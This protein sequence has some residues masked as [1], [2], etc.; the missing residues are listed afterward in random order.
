MK[1]E[2]VTGVNSFARE[3]GQRGLSTPKKK[4]EAPKQENPFMYVPVGQK[5]PKERMGL[6][7]DKK[8]VHVMKVSTRGEY[9]NNWLKTGSWRE[10][11]GGTCY[12]AIIY[13]WVFLALTVAS[14]LWVNVY[15]AAVFAYLTGLMRSQYL[16]GSA[17]NLSWFKG[18]SLI[19]TV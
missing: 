3:W 19:S 18:K 11:S 4:V 15:V 1:H 6:G 12:K 13:G 7:K 14:Y 8:P 2:T 16:L 9:L 10:Y 17:W 5:N